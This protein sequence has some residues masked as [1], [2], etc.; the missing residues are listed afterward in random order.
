MH[1]PLTLTSASATRLP[2]AQS[3]AFIV[4]APFSQMPP[5]HTPCIR[6]ALSV[7]HGSMRS[8]G[9]AAGAWAGAA[10]WLPPSAQA[11]SLSVAGVSS[12][13]QCPGSESPR[14][15]QFHVLPGCL[16]SEDARAV[17]ADAAAVHDAE[18]ERGARL[19]RLKAQQKREKQE[20][21]E[22][23]QRARRGRMAYSPPAVPPPQP[24]APPQQPPTMRTVAVEKLSAG[25]REK[26]WAALHGCV[27][28]F[29]RHAYPGVPSG[30]WDAHKHFFGVRMYTA[31]AEPSELDKLHFDA[32]LFTAVCTLS[33]GFGGGG[34]FFPTEYDSEAPLDGQD[35]NATGV[36]LQPPPGACVLYDGA[37]LHSANPVA[38]GERAVAIF[39][40]GSFLGAEP[41]A[42]L[43]LAEGGDGVG[44]GDGDGDGGSD[45]RVG[46]RTVLLPSSGVGG[47]EAIRNALLA[48]GF[49]EAAKAAPPDAERQARIAQDEL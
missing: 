13:L 4:L 1:L 23:L 35:L 18:A 43:D 9:I 12:L 7:D 22:K 15:A 27:R 34:T 41:G 37:L 11:S 2:P 6:S 10:P 14:A 40:F 49:H 46:A 17:H 31:A 42:P 26:L 36:L 16:T 47:A 21:R 19:R 38:W 20:K 3:L 32:T 29:A 25:S 39:Y 5:R 45:E 44:V 33:G 8:R 24:H 48:T 28:P 30:G